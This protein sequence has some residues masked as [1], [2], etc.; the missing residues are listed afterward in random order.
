LAKTD[1]DAERLWRQGRKDIA[2][3]MGE[4]RLTNIPEDLTVPMSRIAEYLTRC[5]NIAGKHR[6]QIINFGHA[7]DGNFHTNILYNP[8]D[9]DQKKRLEP[10]R[11]DL[12]ALACEL[13][14]TLT[15]EHGIGITKARF[16]NLEH[17]PSALKVMRSVK[18]VLDPNNILNPGKMAL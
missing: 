17:D 6:M 15:G 1:D 11:L 18:Q 12:H 14:G 9:P 2:G 4:L 8:D 13:G 10:T 16:M 5:Q 3:M 7:G